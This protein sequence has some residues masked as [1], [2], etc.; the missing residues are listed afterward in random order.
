MSFCFGLFDG[1][2]IL[3]W[4]CTWAQNPNPVP[5][6][7]V[8]LSWDQGPNVQVLESVWDQNPIPVPLTL[9]VLSWALTNKYLI[10]YGPR[11]LTLFVPD[12]LFWLCCRSWH[13]VLV[14]L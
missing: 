9:F 2:A 1:H 4:L 3:F 8:V 6:T 11:T 7:L 13:F 12:I 5:L 14:V 10:L